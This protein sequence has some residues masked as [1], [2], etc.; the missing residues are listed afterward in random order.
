MPFKLALFVSITTA[1]FKDR[2]DLVAENV[3]LRQQLSCLIHRGP[4]PKLRSVDR[5]FWLLLSRFLPLISAEVRTLI[6]E[7]AE[8]NVGWG[9]PR[10]HGELLKLGFEMSGI[11]VS[12][13]M[14]N[15]PSQRAPGNDGKR[16]YAII[17]T[18]P[19]RSLSCPRRR[20][21]FSTCSLSSASAGDGSFLST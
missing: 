20:L 6:I 2:T 12:R 11:T 3:A 4:R 18:R 21:A 10:I 13:Y 9:T 1:V 7:M 15:V 17:C 19:S 16:S 5:V 8:M 14:P